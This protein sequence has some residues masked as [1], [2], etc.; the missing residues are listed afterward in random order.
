MP[1]SAV[2]TTSVSS[3]SLASRSDWRMSATAVSILWMA[4]C[5]AARS[6]RVA[7]EAGDVALAGRKLPAEV[8]VREAEDAGAM[9]VA[10]GGD[11]GAAGAA[12]GAGREEVGETDT[13]GGEGIDRGRA[14]ARDAV[15]SEMSAE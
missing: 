8:R 12:A 1:W 11:G 2:K 6:A 5:M 3:S 15:A 13:V 10:A 7:Q 9:R 4:P 14:D